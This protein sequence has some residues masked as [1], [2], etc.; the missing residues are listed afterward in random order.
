MEVVAGIG[1]S[2]G[3]L[4]LLIVTG[5]GLRG[6]GRAVG[7]GGYLDGFDVLRRERP[8]ALT[9]ARGGKEG[10]NQVVPRHKV[11]KESN[12]LSPIHLLGQVALPA[13]GISSLCR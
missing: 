9:L 12:Q 7:L 5:F 6:L 2:L 3:L 4:D 10:T 8:S 1:T 13:P 11:R